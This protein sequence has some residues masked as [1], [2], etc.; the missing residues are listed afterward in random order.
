MLYSEAPDISEEK[1]ANQISPSLISAV[2]IKT[3]ISCEYA[4]FGSALGM[5]PR[6]ASVK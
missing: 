1:V 4:V 3:C 2:L 6:K 5:G